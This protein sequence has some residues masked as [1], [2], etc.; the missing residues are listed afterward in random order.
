MITTILGF[1]RANLLGV[2]AVLA[3]VT[4]LI[5]LWKMG[6]RDSVKF[7]IRSLIAKAEQQYGSKTGP[8]KWTEVWAGIYEKIPWYI[9]IFFPKAELEQYI[10]DGLKWLDEILKKPEVNLLTY[11]DEMNKKTAVWLENKLVEITDEQITE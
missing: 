8:V 4:V 6:K 9:R 7:I 10:K 1:L 3:F 5:I 11:N 2:L